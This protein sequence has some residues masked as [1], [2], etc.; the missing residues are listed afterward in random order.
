MFFLGATGFLEWCLTG[1]R[2]PDI[3][4]NQFSKYK[5]KLIENQ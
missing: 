4:L 3:N 1:K 5:I 2:P